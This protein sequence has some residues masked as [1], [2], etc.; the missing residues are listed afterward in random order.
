MFGKAGEVFIGGGNHTDIDSNQPVGSEAGELA[1]FDYA[2]QPFLPRGGEHADF[3]EKQRATVGFLEA[4]GAGL[5]G[6][7]EGTDFVA[8]QLGVEQG[9]GK[10]GAIDR[11][12]RLFPA[13]RQAVQP[14]G[15]HFLAGAAFPHHQNG[16]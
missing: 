5:A 11:H 2:Q 13:R 7:G 14:L 12:Q 3:I 8:E 9:F 6:T 16:A 10:G 15:D 4:A 1:I